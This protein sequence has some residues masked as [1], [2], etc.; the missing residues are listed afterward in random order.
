V[1][2][3]AE[4]DASP[5]SAREL[6]E[7][8]ARDPALTR[9]QRATVLEQLGDLE[10]LAGNDSL[11]AQH[12]VEAESGAFDEH[13]ARTIEVKRYA[14]QDP[15]G[16]AAISALLIGDPRLGSDL[17]QAAAELGEWSALVP[18]L[19]LADYLIG[20]NLYSR[21][22]WRDAYQRLERALQRELPIASVRRE[23]LRTFVFAACASAEWEVARRIL[24][25]YLTDPGLSFARKT[26]M[27]RF[28]RSCR[29]SAS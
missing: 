17:P 13:R 10:L 16:R 24:D 3:C 6:Y 9:V 7:A 4:R 22:R 28:A 29:P 11:A 12:Y 20:K 27:Q 8:M 14:L 26:G 19:G 18:Q 21:A 2:A 25:T 5:G 23:A 1:A 15:T